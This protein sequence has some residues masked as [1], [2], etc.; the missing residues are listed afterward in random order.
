MTLSSVWKNLNKARQVHVLFKTFTCTGRSGENV[1]RCRN[2]P[3]ISGITPDCLLCLEARIHNIISNGSTSEM[4]VMM[5]MMWLLL[6]LL[7][8][9]LCY[10]MQRDEVIDR[11]AM[12]IRGNKLY[13]LLHFLFIRG[14]PI[15]VAWQ[16]GIPGLFGLIVGIVEL[17]NRPENNFIC[18]SAQIQWFVDVAEQRC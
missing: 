6:L 2:L 3:R 10:L 14:A 9:Y 11:L 15:V 5:M 7:D 13:Q 17:E 4:S 16:M 18:F 8:A 12:D 1:I